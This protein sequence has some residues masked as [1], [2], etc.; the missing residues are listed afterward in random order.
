MNVR[1]DGYITKNMIDVLNFNFYYKITNLT[2]ILMHA[3]ARGWWSFD[4]LWVFQ[5]TQGPSQLYKGG[6]RDQD[7]VKIKLNLRLEKLYCCHTRPSLSITG[8][9]SSLLFVTLSVTFQSRIKLVSLF[10]RLNNWL[11]WTWSRK[12]RPFLWFWKLCGSQFEM[13]REA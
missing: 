3:P 7:E 9:W 2:F 4:L 8:R 10:V 12:Y 6:S 1:S 11:W 13:F 5:L